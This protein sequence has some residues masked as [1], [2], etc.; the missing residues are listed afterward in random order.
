MKELCQAGRECGFGGKWTTPC[1]NEAIHGI[2]SPARP[3]ILLCDRHFKE[4]NAAGL[5]VD[6][7][8]GKEEYD[9]RE[10]ERCRHS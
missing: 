9:R 7:N 8:I 1:P 2:T 5:I 6:E 4:V 3:P 10:E